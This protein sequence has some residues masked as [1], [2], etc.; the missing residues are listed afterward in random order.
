MAKRK[1]TPTNEE[2]IDAFTDLF[3]AVE[4]ETPEE[5]DAVL[6]ESGLDPDD[7][8]ARMRAFAQKAIEASPY[9]WRNQA[10][11]LR[12]E[13][14]RLARRSSDLRLSREEMMRTIESLTT[15][16]GRGQRARAAAYY[17]NLEEATDE[18]L[19]SLLDELRYLQNQDEST[20]DEV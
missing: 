4:P 20:D 18:D 19:A 15:G 2:L 16:L 3:N 10:D 9:N 14:E 7:V 12:E 8:A 6:S 13:Q 1:S 11:S 5:I 17:R